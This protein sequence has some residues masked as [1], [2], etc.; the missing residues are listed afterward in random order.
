MISVPLG[1]GK[2][3]SGLKVKHSFYQMPKHLPGSP[4]HEIGVIGG[5]FIEGAS[6]DFTA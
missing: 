6:S 3:N 4:E 1:E 5:T 2:T